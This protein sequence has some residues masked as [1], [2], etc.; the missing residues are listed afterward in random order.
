MSNALK[1]SLF[2]DTVVKIMFMLVAERAEKKFSSLS[3]IRL[4]LYLLE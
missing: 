3:F 1:N 2:I 4:V